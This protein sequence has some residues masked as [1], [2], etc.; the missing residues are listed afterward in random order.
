LKAAVIVDPYTVKKSSYLRGRAQGRPPDIE[1]I[2]SYQTIHRLRLPVPAVTGEK[3][4][5][6]FGVPSDARRCPSVNFIH[7]IPSFLLACGSPRQKPRQDHARFTNVEDV[8]PKLLQVAEAGIQIET[9]HRGN[10]RE[11]L[12]QSRTRQI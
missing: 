10:D 8:R 1:K 7:L 12:K 6:L 11:F 2:L 3:N 9:R 5:G 4:D